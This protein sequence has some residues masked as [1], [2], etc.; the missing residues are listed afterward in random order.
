MEAGC[1]QGPARMYDLKTAVVNA[2]TSVH[3]CSAFRGKVPNRSREEVV[4]TAGH[5][6]DV[7][8]LEPEGRQVWTC[9]KN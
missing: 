3:T 5:I 4:F 7:E 2:H 8:G 9:G 6:W 1:L